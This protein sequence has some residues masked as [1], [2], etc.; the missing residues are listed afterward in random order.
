[1]DGIGAYI[2]DV[3]IYSDFWKNHIGTIKKFF[4]RGTEYRL[5]VN[6]VSNEFCHGTLTFPGHLVGQGQV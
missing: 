4:D 5:T 1:M 2:D 6:L 3:I